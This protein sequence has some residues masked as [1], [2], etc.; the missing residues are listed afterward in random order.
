MASSSRFHHPISG[1]AVTSKFGILKMIH[2]VETILV[3]LL[4]VGLEVYF[5]LNLDDVM[6]TK[7]QK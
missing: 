4:L 5:D 6:K 3:P 2:I 7:M 1:I